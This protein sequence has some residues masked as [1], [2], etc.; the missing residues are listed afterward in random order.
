MHDRFQLLCTA[1]LLF[2][3]LVF[4]TFPA[5]SKT[6]PNGAPKF[7]DPAEAVNKAPSAIKDVPKTG[8]PSAVLKPASVYQLFVKNNSI[9]VR[10]RNV[11][12]LSKDTV[13]K[14]RLKI[15]AGS[16]NREWPFSRVMI[17]PG[18]NRQKGEVVFDT[19]IALKK[20]QS[21]SAWVVGGPV[22]QP[23]LQRL[24]PEMKPSQLAAPTGVIPGVAKPVMVPRGT[25]TPAQP[26]PV[27]PVSPV[28]PNPVTKIDPDLKAALAAEAINLMFCGWI[29][30]FFHLPRETDW[31]GAPG[32]SFA[33]A[34]RLTRRPGTCGSNCTPPTNGML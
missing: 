12:S 32:L 34:L 8:P 7:N 27:R 22:Q 11:E 13:A 20:S 18:L 29:S 21:V 9:H 30:K 26:K 23:V 4:S 28:T 33:T 16:I 25:T 31:N 19:G 14:L 2:A 1:I 17:S 3:L 5:A 15:K 6:T 10:L 24:A